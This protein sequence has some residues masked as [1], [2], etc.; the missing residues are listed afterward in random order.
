MRGIG[1]LELRVRPGPF[2]G[3]RTVFAKREVYDY[4]ERR[5]IGYAVRLPA[6]EVPH[7]HIMLVH[8]SLPNFP[9]ANESVF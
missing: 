9:G 1:A 5:D 4:L 2:G 6:N 7:E 8:D 3:P